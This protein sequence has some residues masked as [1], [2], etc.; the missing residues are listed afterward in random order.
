[1]VRC[2]AHEDSNPSLSINADDGGKV[3]LKCHAGCSAE[4]VVAAISLTM[5][6]LFPKEKHHNRQEISIK[7]IDKPE[8]QTFAT[9]T[10]AQKALERKWG[11]PSAHWTYLDAKGEPC[12]IV[13]RW[14]NFAGK[15]VRPLMRDDSG[16][17]CI[18]AMQSPRPLYNL[19][20]VL[21]TEGTIAVVEGEKAAQAILGLGMVAT[22]SAG[23]AEAAMKTD[24]GPMAGKEVFILPDNDLPGRKYAQMVAGILLELKPAPIVKVVELPGLPAKGDIVDWIE[25]RGEGVEP[26]NLRRE[27]LEYVEKTPFWKPKALQNDNCFRRGEPDLVNLGDIEPETVPWLWPS[28]IPLGRITVLSGRPG[29]GKSFLT[30][31]IAA[32]ISKGQLWPDGGFAPQGETLLISAEDDPADTIVP[33]LIGAD[34]DRRKVSLL[35]AEKIIKKDGSE[36]IVAFDLSNVELIRTA[37]ERMPDC[38]LIV[39]DPVGSYLGRGVDAHRDNEV[40][41]VLAPLAMIAAEKKVAVLMVCHTRKA[42][43]NHADDAVLGSRGFTGLARCVLHLDHDHDNRERKLLLPGKS[44]LQKQSLGLA[45]RI[46]DNPPR[47]DWEPEP[48]DMHADDLIGG[49]N[50]QPGPK[51]YFRKAAVDWLEG[52]LKV[53]AVLALVVKEQAKEAGFSWATIR[54]AQEELGIVPFK[55]DFHSNWFWELPS[56]SRGK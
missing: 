25:G 48:I 41:Q 46:I 35:R 39:I 50:N 5:T 19:P 17:W 45:F 36:G 38:R 28:R 37:L 3:L 26:A 51:P 14:D 47:L 21:Q 30:A 24:W 8:I 23:G 2:P 55:Q 9:A 31:D 29:C 54:R 32:R 4:E 34:A 20:E 43:A 10:D 40:R 12:G 56:C 1:M 27:L 6:D 49:E 22:T 53:G 18:V 44:N 13:L 16:C 52:F 33:R 11:T 42:V 7:I 15:V